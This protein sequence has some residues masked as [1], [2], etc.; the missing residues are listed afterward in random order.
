MGPP[1]SIDGKSAILRLDRWASL[2]F[3]GA[4]D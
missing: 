2:G 1:I 3:N 4:A